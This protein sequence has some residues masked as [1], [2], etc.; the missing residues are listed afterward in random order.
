MHTISFCVMFYDPTV[1]TYHLRLYIP[2]ICDG[3][4]D[5]GGGGF[6]PVSAVRLFFFYFSIFFVG[7][8]NDGFMNEYC[9]CT[10]R[11][12]KKTVLL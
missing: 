11:A 10:H 5:V 12:K 2:S 1:V 3:V 9:V 4:S 7:C 8:K 6:V